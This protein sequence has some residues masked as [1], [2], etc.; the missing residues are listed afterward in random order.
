MDTEPTTHRVPTRRDCLKYGGA[1]VGGGLL[2]GCTG[3]GE[4]G[5]G[6]SGSSGT[7]TGSG[8]S[9]SVT[10]APV[11][12]VEFESIPETWIANNGSWADMGI[13]LGREPPKGLWRPNRYHTHVYDDVPGI[14]VHW[15]DLDEL[16]GKSLSKERFYELGA[17]VHVFDP[18]FVLSRSKWKQA[19]LD[20]IR[21]NVG[22]VFGNSSYSR[23][24]QWHDHRYYSLYE[25]FEKLA[26]VFGAEQ[27][28]RAFEQLHDEFI[29]RVQDRLPPESERPSVAILLVSSNEPEEFYPYPINEGTSYKQWRDLGATS[30]LEEAGI[31]DYYVS[32]G[33]IDYETLVEADPDVL[34]MWDGRGRFERMSREEFQDTLVS[35]MENH[36]VASQLTAVENDAVHR[37]AGIY[38][39]PIINLAWTER[40]AWQLYPDE[41][42]RDEQLFDRQRVADIVAGSVSP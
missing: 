23:A 14:D 41:F 35:F 34:L 8:R 32:G 42:D 28:Y 26:Q 17:D 16:W 37:G 38:Q 4:S 1:A 2:A 24:F 22:P 19:D 21:E 5:N 3:K 33:T 39:G 27:R 7:T 25:A 15:K 20:E 29:G 18:V 40:G 30:A 36:D 11:G 9:H 13:A 10:M 12:D 31:K 6:T